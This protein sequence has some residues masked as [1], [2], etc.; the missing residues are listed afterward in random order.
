MS[1][2]SQT[3]SDRHPVRA[4]L[5]VVLAAVMAQCPGP[6]AGWAAPSPGP[7]GRGGPASVPLPVVAV[8][9]DGLRTSLVVDLGAS[10]RSDRRT[11][12]VTRAGRP[13]AASIAPMMADD[14][15]VVLVLD[16][17]A[18]G[19]ATLPAWLSAGARFAL[20][21]PRASRTVVIADT[22]PASVITGPQR[23]PAGI[24]RALN[25]VRPGGYRDTAGALTLATRQFPDA[26]P[27]RRLV[28]LYTTAPDAGGT[29]ADALVARFRAGG[30]ML[31]VVGTPTASRYWTDVSTA[32][33]GFFAP[34][35]D[36]AVAP[37]LDQ[38]R[39]TLSGRHLIRFATP[40]RRPAEVSVRV[41][42]GDLTLAADVTV[43]A[44]QATPPPRGTPSWTARWLPAAVGVPVLT[45]A[46]LLLLLR[47]SRRR[48]V[49]ADR[50]PGV[51]PAPARGRVPLPAEHPPP[52]VA[53][54]TVPRR[55]PEV[56]RGRATAPRPS[57]P[58]D[59]GSPGPDAA[60]AE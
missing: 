16:T 1:S 5:V 37:A 32:T 15:A 2:S 6:A 8:R 50:P 36:P 13:Q 21:A 33:G 42:T 14:L 9:T 59:P 44:P 55:A 7:D 48:L 40:P 49:P 11:V 18:A 53:R 52:A 31:V 28:V 4:A 51:P 60:G 24:V 34:A 45:A 19:A 35:G 58:P 43:T 46:V 41:G 27:D 30:T 29:A 56:A 22:A 20:E 57:R 17:S 38:V 10:T 47:R 54:G 3:W 26:A 25:T 23:G 12:T 39:A